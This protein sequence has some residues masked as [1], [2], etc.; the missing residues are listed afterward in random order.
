VPTP[1]R[2][3]RP[4][5]VRAPAAARRLLAL[6]AV[7]LGACAAPDGAAAQDTV[8]SG[9]SVRLTYDAGARPTLAVLPV[10]GPAGDSVR[11]LVAR[12]L[13]FGDRVTVA[14]AALALTDPA[15]RVNY[16]AAARAGVAGVVEAGPTHGGG[17]RLTLHDV[18]RRRVAL[19][20]DVPL[21]APV[22][23]P[24]WRLGVHAA[25]DAVE[26]WATG[27]RGVAATRVLF[28]RDRRVWS[29]DSDGQNARPLTDRGA[30]SP[31]WHPEGRAFVHSTLGD[32]GAQQIVA[33][34]YVAAGAGG[35]AAGAA[36]VLA[37]RPVTNLTPS[38]APDGRTVV[39]AHGQED[40][41]DLYAVPFDG[42]P[43]RRMTVGRGSDNVS[44][45][46]APDG[47]R[48]AFTSGRSGHPEVYI[49]DADGTNAE[50]LTEFDPGSG[51]YRSNPDWSPDGRLVAF[52]ALV[53]GQ[54]QVMTVEVR[55]RGVKRLTTAGRNE[56]PSWAPDARHV[57][58][59]STRT[60]A[61]QLFVV[62]A[63][64]GRARQLTRGGGGARMAAWS[65]ALR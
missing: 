12:D 24:D 63:E 2:P 13:D 16:D 7:A 47:R 45:A 44:P 22:F 36:R 43:S 6:A 62:D 4:A 61:A 49:A 30:L 39:F 42:G 8:P 37:S 5:D 60:G 15:G 54:F 41:S 31:A 55:G 28:V 59:T 46:W 14:P 50:L 21:A 1:F 27:V 53:G 18:A 25:S 32:D 35:G 40:G 57:V 48:V 29:V 58:V 11:A 9:V 10:R 38:V 34:A 65:P 64:T 51:N 20:R 56:D 19:V 23:G 52:Q 3:S 33:R 17:L 26:L